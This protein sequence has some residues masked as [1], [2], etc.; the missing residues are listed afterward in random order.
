MF[1]AS[2]TNAS[3]HQILCHKWQV[4]VTSEKEPNKFDL[5][6]SSLFKLDKEPTVS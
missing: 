5:V 4:F 1:Y 6:I 3:Y 2:Q